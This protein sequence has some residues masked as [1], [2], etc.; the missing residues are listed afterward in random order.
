[1]EEDAYGN[2]VEVDIY[3]NSLQE[4]GAQAEGG[5]GNGEQFV[6]Y[7]FPTDRSSLIDS[8]DTMEDS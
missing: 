6:D 4:D 1:M 8:R 2:Q 3:G 5:F 7:D